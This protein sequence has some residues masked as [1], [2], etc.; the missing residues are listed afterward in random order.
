[1]VSMEWMSVLAKTFLSKDFG[2]DFLRAQWTRPCHVHV[3]T[4]HARKPADSCLIASLRF[5]FSPCSR[6]SVLSMDT[7]VVPSYAAARKLP[8]PARCASWPY[9]TSP[10]KRYVKPQWE[11]LASEPDLW[12]PFAAESSDEVEQ[13]FKLHKTRF[14][15]TIGR[16]TY[17]I[18]LENLVQTNRQTSRKRAI[19]REMVL[20]MHVTVHATLAA[21]EHEIR[22][23]RS[24][25]QH[26]THELEL[27]DLQAQQM[28][29]GLEDQHRLQSTQMQQ[30]TQQL[31]LQQLTTQELALQEDLQSSQ[32]Q[33]LTQ[34][35]AVQEDLLEQK[36]AQLH[37]Q[38][39]EIQQLTQEL[40]LQEDQVHEQS[41]QIQQLT[42]E[43][44]LQEDQVHEQSSKLLELQRRLEDTHRQLLCGLDLPDTAT[45]SNAANL[46]GGNSKF[47]R[48]PLHR[49]HPEFCA[50]QDMFLKSMVKH[51][52]SRKSDVWCEP[53]DVEIT[54]IEEVVNSNMQSLYEAART[55]EVRE[56][57]PQG[58][59]E[60]QDISAWKCS[61]GKSG[62]VDLNEYLLFHGCPKGQIESIARS[63]F[64]P[65]MS[66]T[67]VGAMFGQGTY[68][69]ENASKSDLYTTC[70][71]CQADA[72]CLH[73]NHAHGMR[74]MIVA[75][76]LLGQSIPVTSGDPQRRT[77]ILRPESGQE[78]NSRVAYDSHTALPKAR[79]GAIDHTEFIIFKQQ[80]ALLRYVITY[81]HE[82]SCTCHMCRARRDR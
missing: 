12:K 22:S 44:A 41:S 59:S 17:D 65:Q 13:A 81:R 63:G 50:L 68:F 20:D 10:V 66:G 27:Q 74:Q 71:L 76:V 1:M 62:Q 35:L 34:E 26:M 82:Q 58:C 5:N 36:E 7:E 31:A 55:G 61:T 73:C 54:A 56:R 75:R 14:F 25:M 52:A 64:D 19:R 45:L 46:P 21:Q 60:I 49:L 9:P 30:L 51:R 57:N 43:L 28:M 32:M 2:M 15:L 18:D 11:F 6:S 67:A 38:S 47:I 37:V 70:D 8:L 33:Q 78:G 42:Q 16:Y 24:R 3:V 40:A 53:P 79:G 48:R 80:M 29:Q 4:R 39:S 69:A 23:Q 77:A 72:T